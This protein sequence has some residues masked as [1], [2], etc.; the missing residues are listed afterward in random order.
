DPGTWL[1]E[2]R[3]KTWDPL[4]PAEVPWS[5]ADEKFVSKPDQKRGTMN[6]MYVF[7]NGK[8]SMCDATPPGQSGFVA[9]DGTPD[10]HYKDQLQLYTSFDCKQRP[11]TPAEIDAL[12]VSQQTLTF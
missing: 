7:R 8:V 11:V 3:P 9:P 6:V 5:G 2:A 12:T 1:L 4:S 10:P